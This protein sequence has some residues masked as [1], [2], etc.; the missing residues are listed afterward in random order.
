MTFDDAVAEI[1]EH[2]PLNAIDERSSSS[3]IEVC[4]GGILAKPDDPVPGLFVSRELAIEAWCDSML[5]ALG[6]IDHLEAFSFVDG[7]H[8]DKHLMTNQTIRNLQRTCEDRFSV[9]AT[10]GLFTA[11]V[12]D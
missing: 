6:D 4:S 11:T 10:V 12:T 8:C 2:F 1:T 3:R 7:P 5:L 9:T